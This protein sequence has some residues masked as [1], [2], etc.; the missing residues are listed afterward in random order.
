MPRLTI[1]LPAL[2]GVVVQAVGPQV[3]LRVVARD[4]GGVAID[5]RACLLLLHEKRPERALDLLLRRPSDSNDV[6]EHE[7]FLIAAEPVHDVQVVMLAVR[8]VVRESQMA[9]LAELHLLR[10]GGGIGCGT[11]RGGVVGCGN[12]ELMP[13][14]RREL[15]AVA[16]EHHEDFG[17]ELVVGFAPGGEGEEQ[18]ALA[19]LARRT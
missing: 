14:Y 17:K 13:A 11:G 16:D 9:L 15:T 18:T 3:S 12:P 1:R 8:P 2:D 7:P 5:P 4:H 19:S 10:G 6:Q